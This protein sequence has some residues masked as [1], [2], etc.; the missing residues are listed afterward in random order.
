MSLWSRPTSIPSGI[1][2]H[3]AVWP[4]YAWAKKCGDL[5]PFWRGG[6]G[7][8]S[9]TVSLGC[10][11][12]FLLSGIIFIHLATRDMGQILGAVSLWGGDLGF[13]VTQCGQGRGLPAC[14]VSSRSVQLFGHNTPTLQTGQTDRTGQTDMQTDR[15]TD[16]QRSD[17]I[18][19]T[20]LQTVAQKPR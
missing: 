2:M 10:R 14:Q 16:R 15:Q 5:S 6:A 17:S 3:A 20:V 18:G 4:Q 11:R 1:L 13:Y 8:P 9:N 19:R 12:T 7:S